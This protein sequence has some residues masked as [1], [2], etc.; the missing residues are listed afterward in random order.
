MLGRLA[1]W[2]NPSPNH[3]HWVG[4][5]SGGLWIIQFTILSFRQFE[6]FWDPIDFAFEDLKSSMSFHSTVKTIACHLEVISHRY[7]LYEM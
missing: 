2:T 7:E 4:L 3:F 5:E 6:K 1:I